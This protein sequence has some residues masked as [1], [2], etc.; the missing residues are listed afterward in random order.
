MSRSTDICQNNGK[1]FLIATHTTIYCLCN[2]CFTDNQYDIEC[3]LKSLWRHSISKENTN[4]Y[5]QYIGMIIIPDIFDIIVFVS[6]LLSL[7]T[8]LFKKKLCITNMDVYLFIFS[9]TALLSVV[10]KGH[11]NISILYFIINQYQKFII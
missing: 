8:F 4:A 9:L 11:F 6:N 2:A 1:Y 10:Y 7:Q 5:Y 3:Y